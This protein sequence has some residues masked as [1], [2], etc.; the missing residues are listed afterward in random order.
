MKTEIF[1]GSVAG[2]YMI[3]AV[4]ADG[5]RRI[6]SDWFDNLITT[7]GLNHLGTGGAYVYCMVGSGNTPPTNSDTA[8]QTPVA[9]TPD[10]I[11]DQ[12]GSQASAPYFGWHRRTFRF[13]IGAAAGN[14]SE[15]G[16]GW[17]NAN[18]FSRALIVDTEGDPTTITVLSDE[19]LD[20]TY[21]FRLYPPTVDQTSTINIS[22][23]PYDVVVRASQVNSSHWW[24]DSISNN[25]FS[26]TGFRFKPFTG[27]IG[28]ITEAPSGSSNS[29]DYD[30]LITYDAYS[31]NSL[32]R[33]GKVEFGL[34]RGNLSGGIGSMQ[35]FRY[36]G[37]GCG[38]YQMSFDPKIPKD[39]FKILSLNF[40][41]SWARHTG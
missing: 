41:F 24:P 39:M 23:V 11:A 16:V 12:Q 34:T 3:E 14:L 6:V 9:S 32:M 2:R 27:D 4:K 13:P 18:V 8:L 40:S 20:V 36:P 30:G 7:A 21:E 5:S 38:A 22:G 31:N 28:A 37:A 26:N 19:A 17:N 33:T 25:G 10:V 35:M 15:I 29:E 1:G